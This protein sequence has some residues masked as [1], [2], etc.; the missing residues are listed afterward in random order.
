M[1]GF[2]LMGHLV[3]MLDGVSA[4]VEFARVPVLPEAVELAAAGV[5]PG[6]SRRNEDAHA[7]FVDIR[8]LGEEQRAVLFDAQ[9]SGGL[10]IA[11]AEEKLDALLSGFEQR[12]LQGAAVIGSLVEGDGRIEVVG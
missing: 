8:G 7:T 3:Q 6:G 10:L 2:G 9:T 1:T 5:L 12:G 4:R 11:I